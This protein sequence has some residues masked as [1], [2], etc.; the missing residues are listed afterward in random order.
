MNAKEINDWPLPMAFST[1]IL[2]AGS[3]GCGKSIFVRRLLHDL[4]RF[5]KSP[6]RKILYC[7]GVYQPLI[8]ELEDRFAGP[9]LCKAADNCV[10]DLESDC[11][12]QC[13]TDAASID[14]STFSALEGLPTEED[15]RELAGK[16]RL[17]G[18]AREAAFDHSLIVLDD[19][20]NEALNSETVSQLFVK[21]SHHFN[22]TVILVMH[23]V[24]EKGKFAKL[25]RNNA[26]H[27]VLFKNLKAHDQIERLARQTF[28]R[29]AYKFLSAYEDA[30]SWKPSTGQCTSENHYL[31]VDLSNSTRNN[32]Y[33]LRT[34]VFNEAE[35]TTIYV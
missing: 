4:P 5:F 24:F 15:L 7:Y 27:M 16:P 30:T 28:G 33:R 26:H 31:W 34:D 35:L 6:P 1:S 21:F 17:R 10:V 25:I 22:Q 20:Q 11:G 8:A 19:L 29:Q 9:Q 18:N 13:A 32:L 14:S 3:S 2:I 23:N 12:V